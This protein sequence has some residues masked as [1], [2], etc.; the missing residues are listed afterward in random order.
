[1]VANNISKLKL[2]STKFKR[3]VQ[4]EDDNIEVLQEKEECLSQN[5]IEE[6]KKSELEN[7]KVQ[8]QKFKDKFKNI[9]MLKK[10]QDL[11]KDRMDR[12]IQEEDN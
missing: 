1:M 4:Q 3:K 8:A 10:L 12:V 5:I 9:D 7:E 11:D 6:A 2:Q